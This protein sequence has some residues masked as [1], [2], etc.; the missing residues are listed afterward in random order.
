VLPRLPEKPALATEAPPLTPAA[1]ND[2]PLAPPKSDPPVPLTID[3]LVPLAVDA[4]PS[5]PGLPL[6]DAQP[7]LLDAVKTIARRKQGLRVMK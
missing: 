6:F 3:P 5:L 4:L 2:D 7:P 1:P